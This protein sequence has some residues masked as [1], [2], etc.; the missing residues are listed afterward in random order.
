M[1]VSWLINAT[2]P[3]NIANYENP[4]GIGAVL[5]IFFYTRSI[6]VARVDREAGLANTNL[7]LWW[8]RIL[9]LSRPNPFRKRTI[10]YQTILIVMTIITLGLNSMFP[11]TRIAYLSFGAYLI[12]M[13]LLMVVCDMRARK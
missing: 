7:P 9:F 10:I 4:L 11:S 6:S 2:I 8:R 3:N 13:V 12:G 1:I 5:F